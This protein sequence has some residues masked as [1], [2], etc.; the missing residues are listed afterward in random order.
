M[1]TSGRI[2]S[3]ITISGC[4]YIPV[5]WDTDHLKIHI[6]PIRCIKIYDA[7][8][9]APYSTVVSLW[10]TEC[11]GLRVKPE[12]V[13]ELY[14][15]MQL[16]LKNIHILSVDVVNQISKLPFAACQNL[17]LSTPNFNLE[18]TSV[19]CW[20]TEYYASSKRANPDNLTSLDVVFIV[21]I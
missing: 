10:D 13:F 2:P 20:D 8:S 21:C 16:L 4:Q 1:V 6:C 18:I 9:G 19:S 15:P 12:A 7:L 17:I 11:Y 3:G 14:T 5:S